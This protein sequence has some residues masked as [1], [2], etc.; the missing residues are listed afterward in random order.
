MGEHVAKCRKRIMNA[1][2]DWIPAS[3]KQEQENE[4]SRILA[5]AVD[6][7]KQLRCQRAYWS[8]RYPGSDIGQ[9]DSQRGASSFDENIM[10]EKFTQDDNDDGVSSTEYEE[11]NIEVIVTPGLFKRGNTDGE[12]FEVEYCRQKAIVKC[13]T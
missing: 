9:G 8:V 3:G 7:S 1:I 2:G 12:Q 6:L 11:K 10:V 5:E 4:L 13:C